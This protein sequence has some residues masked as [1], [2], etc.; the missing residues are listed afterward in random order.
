MKSQRKEKRIILFLL[1]AVIL[2]TVGF[3]TYAGFLNIDGT[4]TV[5]SNK[6]SIGFDAESYVE[7]ENS[8][9]AK[10]KN[11]TTDSYDFAV[12][13]AK[14]NT[15]YEATV[16]VKNEG[17]FVANVT[18]LEMEA[19]LGTAALTDVEKKYFE[20]VVIYDGQTY[21]SSTGTVAL[22]INPGQSKALTVKVRYLQPENSED[23]PT[24]DKTIS[25]SGSLTYSI[26]E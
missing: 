3:A 2:M 26:A 9:S 1:I 5:K 10:S 15:F 4:V 20:Y 11:I 24:T 17:T 22:P 23:L 25:V 6:W 8:V 19:K 13:L 18:K 12:E 14:P 7:S 16:N 21:T